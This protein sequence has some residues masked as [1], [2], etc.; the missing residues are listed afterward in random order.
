M[1]INNVGKLNLKI[2][3]SPETQYWLSCMTRTLKSE[4]IFVLRA[5]MAAGT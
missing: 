5:M 1:G 3:F 2:V 4:L